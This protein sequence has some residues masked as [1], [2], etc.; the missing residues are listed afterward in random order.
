MKE[1]KTK[2]GRDCRS[3]SLSRE[4]HTHKCAVIGRVNL[5]AD[6]RETKVEN[7]RKREKVTG[8]LRVLK[9]ISRF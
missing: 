3:T 5:R 6:V 1:A 7:E 2:G 8:V 4:R 9:I